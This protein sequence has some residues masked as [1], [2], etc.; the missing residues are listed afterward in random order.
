MDSLVFE[1]DGYKKSMILYFRGMFL[2]V[3]Y[4]VRFCYHLFHVVDRRA[5]SLYVYTSRP[6]LL[7]DRFTR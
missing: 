3:K 4:M 5:K 7:C 1:E 2:S 6:H